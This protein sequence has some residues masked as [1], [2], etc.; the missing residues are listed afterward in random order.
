MELQEVHNLQS[1]A[2]EL[3]MMYHQHI[4]LTMQDCNCSMYAVLHVQFDVTHGCALQQCNHQ[5]MPNALYRSAK[6]TLQ[7]VYLV[8]AR[9]ALLALLCHKQVLCWV[10]EPLL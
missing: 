4:L 9:S 8:Y 6:W 10:C 7:H 5:S 2:L 1:N 3:L